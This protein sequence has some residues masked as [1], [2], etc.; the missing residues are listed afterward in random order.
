[1]KIISEPITIN[2][3]QEL[4]KEIG[5]F[6]IKVVVDLEKNILC[7]GAKMHIDEEQELINNGSMKENLWC[8]GYRELITV[9]KF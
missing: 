2:E 7:A 3:L 6:F 1:M 8:G 5:G 4:A 9:Q